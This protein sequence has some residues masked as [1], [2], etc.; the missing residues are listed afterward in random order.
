MCE[1]MTKQSQA[2]RKLNLSSTKTL[3]LTLRG[4]GRNLPFP[5]FKADSSITF[6]VKE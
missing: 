4:V 3:T 6:S 1:N 5:S 2:D